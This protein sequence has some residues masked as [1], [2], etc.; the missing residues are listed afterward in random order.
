MAEEDAIKGEAKQ[1]DR[2]VKLAK[3]RKSRAAKATELERVKG[4]ALVETFS[5][6]KTLRNDQLSDQLKIWKLV[7]KNAAANKTTGTRTELVLALQPLMLGKFGDE[8]NDL[9]AGDDGLWGQ[10]LRR[11]RAAGQGEGKRQKKS[12]RWVVQGEWE[13]DFEADFIIERLIDRLVADGTTVVPGREGIKAGTVLY[14][15]L[16]APA[17][18]M[19][20]Q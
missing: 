15:V 13:W 20:P 7:E 2:D 9:E 4:I 10:G 8:A 3:K 19:G 11:R 12:K 17:R 6:L 1:P 5:A 18:V 16:W 14:K